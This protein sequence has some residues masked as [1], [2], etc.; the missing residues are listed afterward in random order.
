VFN[1]E[2]TII[3]ML[4]KEK[5]SNFMTSAELEEEIR[6]HRAETKRLL[7]EVRKRRAKDAETSS[8][9]PPDKT[10]D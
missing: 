3:S 2:V 10:K 4:F 8:E 9:A 6:K 1:Y 5:P 7:A